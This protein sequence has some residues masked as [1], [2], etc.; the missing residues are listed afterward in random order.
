[1]D[2]K[3][4]KPIAVVTGKSNAEYWFGLGPS[5]DASLQAALADAI[6]DRR[7]HTLINTFVDRKAYCFPFC[8]LPFYMRVETSITGTLVAL[9]DDEGKPLPSSQLSSQSKPEGKASV[10][11][12]SDQ[13]MKPE[14]GGLT[15]SGDSAS[16]VK[17]MKIGSKIRIKT[18]LGRTLVGEYLGFRH[19]AIGVKTGS[20][21][22]SKQWISYESVESVEAVE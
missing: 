8:G 22:F 11:S 4:E 20:T 9:R 21:A 15:S 10:N 2:G 5:G 1:M 7:G 13:T 19:Q 6:R 18:K 12:A 14:P 3:Y 16:A 17:A